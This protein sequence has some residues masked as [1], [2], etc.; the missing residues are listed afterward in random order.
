M[1]KLSWSAIM[2]LT[3]NVIYLTSESTFRYRFNKDRMTI[4]IPPPFG[5]KSS[6]ELGIPIALTIPKMSLPGVELESRQIPIQTFTVPS[7]YDLTVPL[8][9]M[10]AVASKVNSNYYNWEG[11]AT[12]GNNTIDTHIYLAKFKV[13]ADSPIELLSF[14]SEGNLD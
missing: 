5:G 11:M 6:E 1:A 7:E 12:A 9:G 8:M 4:T 13:M 10:V 14:T 3:N 2:V